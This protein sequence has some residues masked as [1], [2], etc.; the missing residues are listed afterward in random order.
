MQENIDTNPKTS[1]RINTKP[2]IINKTSQCGASISWFNRARHVK[3]K[4][5]KDASYITHIQFELNSI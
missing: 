1:D 4:K 5:H 2:K 3:T